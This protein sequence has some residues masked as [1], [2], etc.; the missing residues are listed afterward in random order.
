MVMRYRVG[1]EDSKIISYVDRERKRL[2][3]RGVT[4]NCVA[5]L[6]ET[7]QNVQLVSKFTVYCSSSTTVLVRSV[8]ILKCFR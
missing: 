3:A 6:D 1:L 7:L 8:E 2:S 5:C 4:K